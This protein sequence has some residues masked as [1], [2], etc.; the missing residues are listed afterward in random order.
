V[1]EQRRLADT[2]LAAEDE[3]PALAA[4]HAG[5]QPIQL[6]ALTLT[7]QQPWPW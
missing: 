2:R 1:L 5:D 3:H 7:A 4:P 6:L